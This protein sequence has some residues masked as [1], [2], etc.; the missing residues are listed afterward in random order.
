MTAMR[1]RITDAT[2]WQVKL[3]ALMQ[4]RKYED[5]DKS[6]SDGPEGEKLVR[7]AYESIHSAIDA[8]STPAEIELAYSKLKKT[9]P[10]SVVSQPRASFSR[11]SDYVESLEKK[12]NTLRQNAKR[13]INKL[14]VPGNYPDVVVEGP[15]VST[16]MVS[17]FHDDIEAIRVQY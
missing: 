12:V 16:S 13:A 15:D 4:Y 17:R 14:F 11:H 9:N 5:S 8:L 6:E 1:K 10:E 7:E 3:E 2:D